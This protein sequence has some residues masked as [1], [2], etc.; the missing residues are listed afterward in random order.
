[1]NAPATAII[2]SVLLAFAPVPAQSG[3]DDVMADLKCRIVNDRIRILD[4]IEEGKS[5]LDIDVELE[6]HRQRL[7]DLVEGQSQPVIAASAGAYYATSRMVYKAR[8]GNPFVVGQEVDIAL[9]VLLNRAADMP[10]CAFS[11]DV[12][13]LIDKQR[14]D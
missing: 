13:D 8:H 10:G 7:S 9:V 5:G 12:R 3:E 11:E 6:K 4:M 1:M 2:L 14:V